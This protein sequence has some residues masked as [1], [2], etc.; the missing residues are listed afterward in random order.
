MY[1][2]YGVHFIYIVLG[3]TTSLL[4]KYI[5]RDPLYRQRVLKR[6]LHTK[7]RYMQFFLSTVIQCERV[8]K[9]VVIVGAINKI[10]LQFFTAVVESVKR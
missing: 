5:S 8:K 10:L 1:T 4:L 3:R 9:N 7:Q 2:E 6:T